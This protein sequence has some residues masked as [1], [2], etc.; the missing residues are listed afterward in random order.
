MNNKEK[1]M[2]LEN[3]M[4][5][6]FSTLGLIIGFILGIIPF[7]IALIGNYQFKLG[8][9]T[10]ELQQIYN[11]FI[12]IIGAMIGLIFISVVLTLLF[13]FAMAF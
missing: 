9:D 4:P 6:Q 8:Y 3:Q 11:I 10:K 2:K 5:W 13:A 1:N 7:M 12:I